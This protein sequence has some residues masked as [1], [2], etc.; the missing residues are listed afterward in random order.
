MDCW[1][2]LQSVARLLLYIIPQWLTLPRIIK[3]WNTGEV[4]MNKIKLYIATAA[5][6]LL[7]L[8]LPTIAS[9]QWG[10]TGNYPNNRGNNNN[11]YNLENT[12]DNLKNRSKSFERNLDRA[13]DNSRFDDRN[14]EKRL[15]DLAQDFRKA[16]DS[17]EK[18]YGRGRNMN[19]G[20]ADAQRMLNIGSQLGSI[21][22]NGRLDGNVQNE[23]YAIDNDL[24]VVAN[25]Y[26]YSYNNNNRNNNRNNRNNR[27][28]NNRGW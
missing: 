21:L 23:W 22:R 8:G 27:G 16:A 28:R 6:S 10:N 2:R 11:Y 18:S 15:N 3:N 25:A 12:A 20:S 1:R 14:L 24:R 13:L 17:F 9:A 19:G 26:G 4:I 5:F 7:V